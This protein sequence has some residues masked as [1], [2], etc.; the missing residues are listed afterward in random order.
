[1]DTYTDHTRNKEWYVRPG[2]PRPA[3]MFPD[4]NKLGL[5]R[6]M[7]GIKYYRIRK[8]IEKI[9]ELQPRPGNAPITFSNAMK[10]ISDAGIYIDSADILTNHGAEFNTIIDDI[11]ARK[12]FIPSDINLSLFPH[13]NIE[14]LYSLAPEDRPVSYPKL[15]HPR[16]VIENNL[17][18]KL[19]ND[20]TEDDPIIYEIS[21]D[22]IKFRHRNFRTLEIVEHNYTDYNT[23]LSI[24]RT[25]TMNLDDDDKGKNNFGKCVL[26]SYD[27]VEDAY[28]Y[29][30]EFKIFFQKGYTR[31]VSNKIDIGDYI[32]YRTNFIASDKIKY[33]I[34]K[35][36]IPK[37]RKMFIMDESS[38]EFPPES[39]CGADAAPEGA[40]NVGGAGLEAAQAGGYYNKYQKYLQKYL[41]N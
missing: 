6:S 17:I 12:T 5:L 39:A 10:Q 1:M 35:S 28:L 32:A 11:M 26:N 2:R 16:D 4:A 19:V 21:T 22:T 37:I 38:Y 18:P 3:E 8:M 41:Y 33:Y 7:L 23:V 36:D 40:P 9:I 14:D 25:H 15:R 24:V 31:G 27:I 30:D 13:E 34:P 20:A 29:P